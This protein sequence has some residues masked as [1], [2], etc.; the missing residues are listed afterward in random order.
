MDGEA[1]ARVL[2]A[3]EALARA[4]RSTTAGEPRA[5]HH[6]VALVFELFRRRLSGIDER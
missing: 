5:L 3:V 4:A 2:R 1:R 6:A